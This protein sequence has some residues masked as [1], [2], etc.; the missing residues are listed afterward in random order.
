M[1]G[2]YLEFFQTLQYPRH[3]P[4][5]LISK[6]RKNASVDLQS[7]NLSSACEFHVNFDVS[8]NC[9]SSYFHV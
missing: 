3:V 7:H 5:R 9:A 8:E 6:L 2:F 4:Q 1:Y